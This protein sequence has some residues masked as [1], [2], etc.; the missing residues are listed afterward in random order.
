MSMANQSRTATNPVGLLLAAAV[1][2]AW[3][4]IHVGA[5]FG[6]WH[7]TA[8]LS[9]VVAL[10]LVQAWL[11]TGLFIIAHD[12]MHGSL[13]PGRAGLN[14]AVG[15]LC[16]TLYAGLSYRALLPQHHAH[17]A[18]P[19]TDRDPDFHAGEPRRLLPWFARFFRGYYTHAQIARITIAALVYMA[20]GASLTAIAIFWAIPALLALVQLFVFGTWLPHRHSDGAFADDHRARSIAL[21]PLTSLL[22]CFHFGGY[23]HE[24]HLNPGTP[25][26]RLPGLRRAEMVAEPD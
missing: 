12:C 11:S 5:I 15:T 23:H 1:I 13:A 4:T 8:P 18:A 17:H 3:L 21:S 2:G 24:H 6:G 20:L 10:V 19:G 16:L 7:T 14:T 26:W 25:W 22:T 9:L